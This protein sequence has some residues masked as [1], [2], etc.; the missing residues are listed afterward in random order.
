MTNP[1]RSL[2]REQLFDAQSRL[3]SQC[4]VSGTSLAMNMKGDDP[5]A[6]YEDLPYRLRVRKASND[7]QARVADKPKR[8]Y[9][10]RMPRYGQRTE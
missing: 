5:Y 6:P 8:S 7:S 10:R 1:F 9:T 4:P 3:T 2:T